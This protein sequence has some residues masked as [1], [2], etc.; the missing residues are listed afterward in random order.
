[1]LYTPENCGESCDEARFWLLERG[2]PFLEARVESTADLTAFRRLGFGVGFPALAVG[3]RR[4]SG[5][6]EPH[7]Q[8][9]L[10]QAG[11]PKPSRLPP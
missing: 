10:N 4:F 3:G 9:A 7:W 11:F 2:I 8:N 1:M 5:F 6:Q